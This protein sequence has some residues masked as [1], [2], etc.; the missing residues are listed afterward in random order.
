MQHRPPASRPTAPAVPPAEPVVVLATRFEFDLTSKNWIE[1]QTKIRVVNANKHFE[2]GG[3]RVCFEVDEID[4]EG[5]STPCVA[6]VFKKNIPDVVKVDYFNEAMAQCMSDEFAQNFNKL[7]T[8]VKISFLMCNVVVLDKKYIPE[9]FHPEGFFSFRTKDTHEVAFVME[10]R[11]RGV[12]TKYNNNFGEVYEAAKDGGTQSQVKRRKVVYLAAEAFSHFTLQESGGSMLVCDLQGVED[13]F[14]DPQIHTEDGKGLGMGNM[15]EEGITKWKDKHV[16]NDVCRTL[17]LRSLRPE[18]A[19]AAGGPPRYQQALQHPVV[20][21]GPG[22]VQKPQSGSTSSNGSASPPAAANGAANGG[23]GG[24]AKYPMFP[25][26]QVVAAAPAPGP[27]PPTPP[28]TYAPIPMPPPPPQPQ[29]PVVPL[30]QTS[31]AVGGGHYNALYHQMRQSIHARGVDT[32]QQRPPPAP[33]YYVPQQQ[34]QQPPMHMPAGQQQP[35]QQQVPFYAHQPPVYQQQPMQQQVP[36]RGPPPPPPLDD[37]LPRHQLAQPQHFVPQPNYNVPHPGGHP[38]PM[39]PP[40]AAG[41]SMPTAASPNTPKP[42][43][44]MT[45]DEQLAHA[46]EISLLQR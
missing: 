9:R 5:A 25:T 12:F 30:Q 45:E 39:R 44:Q 23:G 31:N 35:Q 38:Q 11:F 1:H 22:D 10:P 34:Q 24:A 4:D 18:P 21:R 27:A 3:M 8:P 15:G 29:Q 16:C 14:T 20:E 28:P 33:V 26:A 2:A 36:Y 13:F 41:P 42:I 32:T 17:G 43:S 6:K 7:E 46:I 19:S 37:G 40:G